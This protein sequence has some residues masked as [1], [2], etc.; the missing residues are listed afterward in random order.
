MVMVVVDA[1]F[2]ASC[3]S[4]GLNPSKKTVFDQHGKG[5]VYR[6]TRDGTDVQLR[7]IGD[8][9]RSYVRT[10][11]DRAQDGDALGRRLDAAFA[12]L[13]NRTET[14]RSEA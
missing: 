12:K 6:L 7:E 14:H 3:G 10:K 13:V 2:V 8:F 9:V 5:V 1:I 11:R 4:N